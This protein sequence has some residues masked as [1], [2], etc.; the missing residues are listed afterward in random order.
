MYTKPQ[1]TL[2]KAEE[3]EKL[4]QSLEI[5]FKVSFANWVA[6][7]RKI[8]WKEEKTYTVVKG[9]SKSSTKE[10]RTVM[11]TTDI[12]VGKDT[13]LTW[14]EMWEINV[15]SI[16]KEDFIEKDKDRKK[17][18][19]LP[20]MATCS[21]GSIGSLLASSFCERINSCANQVLTLGNTLLSDGDMEKLVMCRMNEDFIVFMRQQYP[22]VANEQFEFGILKAEDN[23][24]EE[25]E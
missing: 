23:E 9:T 17:Y 18:G 15:V 6:D 20:K 13:K 8:Q 1:I 24:E 7:A 21:K 5:E 12:P 4:T 22:E 2:K 25:D 10:M 11:Q 19:W 16:M 3:E 14:R